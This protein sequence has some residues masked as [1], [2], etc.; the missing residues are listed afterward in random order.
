MNQ[1]RVRSVVPSIITL[2]L[3]SSPL[4]LEAPF[5]GV[6]PSMF[7]ELAIGAGKGWIHCS[8]QMRTLNSSGAGR[9]QPTL[10]AFIPDRS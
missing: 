5:G 3:V 6:M 8:L 4:C 1:G 2:I 7:K 9:G 10:S